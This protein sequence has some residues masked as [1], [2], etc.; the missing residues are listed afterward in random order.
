MIID[1][2]SLMPVRSLKDSS[3]MERRPLD[4][5]IL[6]THSISLAKKGHTNLSSYWPYSVIILEKYY[7]KH[8]ILTLN[9]SNWAGLLRTLEEMRDE[10]LASL[11]FCIPGPVPRIS[12]KERVWKDVCSKVFRIFL[13]IKWGFDVLSPDRCTAVYLVSMRYY[14]S[15]FFVFCLFSRDAIYTLQNNLYIYEC[16]TLALDE[17]VL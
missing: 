7:C 6:I 13:W 1:T 5:L 4:Q 9:S 16:K 10:K 17:A 11:V 3:S 2:E 14:Y 12:D 15:F 8:Y